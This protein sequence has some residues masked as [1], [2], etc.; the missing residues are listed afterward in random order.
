MRPV[1]YSCI[2]FLAVCANVLALHPCDCDT[3]KRQQAVRENRYET[4]Y[5]LDSAALA[6]GL[7][8]M[9]PDSALVQQYYWN[10]LVGASETGRSEVLKHCLEEALRLAQ[11]FRG[12]APHSELHIVAD[13]AEHGRLWGDRFRNSDTLIE[14]C[15]SL[16][17]RHDYQSDQMGSFL[18]HSMGNIYSRIRRDTLRMMSYYSQAIA[19]TDRSRRLGLS[20]NRY[21]PYSVR[22]ERHGPILYDLG[23]QFYSEL[24]DYVRAAKFFRIGINQ[25]VIDSPIDSAGVMRIFEQ[26][27]TATSLVE[28]NSDL[29]DGDT[30]FI[31]RLRQYADRLTPEQ[32]RS[33]TLS[34]DQLWPAV[35]RL[36]NIYNDFA[37]YE[38]AEQLHRIVLTLRG[39]QSG[40]DSPDVAG[41]LNNIANTFVSRERYAEAK[42]LFEDAL[43]RVVAAG[44]AD[45]DLAIRLMGNLSDVYVALGEL[46]EPEKMLLRCLELRRGHMNRS[47][48]GLAYL[49]L[50]RLYQ[51]QGRLSEA[52]RHYRTSI[53]IT[54]SIPQ[55]QGTFMAE[56][57]RDL[58]T[59]L[60]ERARP[61]EAE[62]LLRRALQLQEQAL[63]KSHPALGKTLLH[64][65]ELYQYQQRTEEAER[66]LR[67]AGAIAR[68]HLGDTSMAYL[69]PRRKLAELFSSQ[70]RYD[71]ADSIIHDCIAITRRTAGERHPSLVPLLLL[72]IEIERSRGSAAIALNLLDTANLIAA[73]TIGQSHPLSVQLLKEE[74]AVQ[75]QLGRMPAADSLIVAGMKLTSDLYGANHPVVAEFLELR[76]MVFAKIRQFDS[77]AEVSAEALRVRIAD[78]LKNGHVLSERDAITFAAQLHHARDLV[79]SAFY[80]AGP[81]AATLDSAV[82][83]AL[84]NTKGLVLDQ[85]SRR[86][87]G[88]F[89]EADS[90]TLR[91]QRQVQYARY[92]LSQLVLHS[93]RDHSSS[94]RD[95]QQIDSLRFTLDSLERELALGKG[96]L[97]NESP[98]MVA[99][100]RINAML[101]AGAMAI[102]YTRFSLFS[103]DMETS[104]P[105]YAA[106]VL[107]RGR[108]PRLYFPGSAR[109]V[110]SQISRYSHHMKEI[111]QQTGLPS[112]ADLAAYGEIVRP[113]TGALL[114]NNQA[115]L[116]RYNRLIVSPDDALYALSFAGLPMGA[117]AYLSESIL[118]TYA[119]H[120]RGQIASTAEPRGST[121]LSIGGPTFD[122]L[123][124]PIEIAAAS[125]DGVE[126]DESTHFLRS[127]SAHCSILSEG[128]ADL[129]S[130]RREAHRVAE[131]WSS[132]MGYRSN[133]RVG[134]LA[135]EQYLKAFAGA[136]GCIHLATHGFSL[137]SECI[138]GTSVTGDDLPERNQL[139]RTGLC[140]AGIN[141]RANRAVD[142]RSDDGLLTAYEI[143]VLDL[144]PVSLVVLSACESGASKG[145]AGE[146]V[147]GLRRAFE[148]AGVE[149][150]VSS[151][152]DVDDRRTNRFMTT[153]YSGMCDS[154]SVARALQQAQLAE[155][156][157]LRT[158]KRVDH[159]AL[160][161]PFVVH[162]QLYDQ[163]D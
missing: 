39:K 61:L 42:Q 72:K 31:P 63:G 1:F 104:S 77:M 86:N 128:A 138:S 50:G 51:L 40:E 65:G 35:S 144:R 163:R 71:L 32:A 16:S 140:L 102:E 100:A 53:L 114:P 26:P 52:E 29:V 14:W 151:L 67:E 145:R 41:T 152:W 6:C 11:K 57:Y 156:K 15:E 115:A 116:P 126:Q 70:R 119:S 110:D 117:G 96:S 8:E 23:M 10:I 56:S 123:P 60:L 27:V 43:R 83:T 62:P 136:Y 121:L 34:I 3:L 94:Q 44:R 4:V 150:I 45:S 109:T 101:G 81:S 139:L 38:E 105:W 69:A 107:E 154:I 106:I 134:S 78:V 90:T 108:A 80:A 149:T 97:R 130:A 87:R 153:F 85:E 54:D 122:S 93:G 129:P 82:A 161:A 47:L 64:L 36:A 5:L 148:I 131:I 147:Y 141:I 146:G 143:A 142:D 79:L 95:L 33:D 49:D 158:N 2:T 19:M 162:S 127:L 59:V 137:P 103:G 133:V 18:L 84:L 91:Q 55:M 73:A 92:R 112:T 157:L 74:A 25:F 89:S 17:Q 68:D 22:P 46:W 125:V 7:R 37:R 24:G 135:T 132:R 160:W 159:P 118:V 12:T 113:L 99:V 9:G 58:A 66:C 20:S 98:A 13:I 21:G 76:A 30:L 124:Q 48:E 88:I 111:M 28:P 120:L 155:L 75:L